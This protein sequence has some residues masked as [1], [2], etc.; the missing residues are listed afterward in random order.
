MTL[1]LK[2]GS[3]FWFEF[4]AGNNLRWKKKQ[5]ANDEYENFRRNYSCC[6]K[7]DAI[8]SKCNVRHRHV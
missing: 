8:L 2:K 4:S 3:D 1:A 7:G 5:I 6:A